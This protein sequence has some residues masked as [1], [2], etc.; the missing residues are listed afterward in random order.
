MRSSG[1]LT[2]ILVQNATQ[3]ITTQHRSS[4]CGDSHRLA[5]PRYPL[6]HVP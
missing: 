5:R 3:T 2:E 1:S 4:L 6:V